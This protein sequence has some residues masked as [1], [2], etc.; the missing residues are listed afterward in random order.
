MKDITVRYYPQFPDNP[1]NPARCNRATATIDINK[2]VWENLSE[3]QRQWWMEHERGHIILNTGDEIAADAYAFQQVAG[4]TSYSLIQIINAMKAVV[5]GWQNDRHRAIQIQALQFAARKGSTYAQ[6]LLNKHTTMKQTSTPE[7]IAFNSGNVIV[8][9]RTTDTIPPF[10]F[11]RKAPNIQGQE[12]PVPQEPKP[13]APIASEPPVPTVPTSNPEPDININDEI[14]PSGAF[15]M[16]IKGSTTEADVARAEADAAIASAGAEAAP[17]LYGVAQTE[18]QNLTKIIA[19][20]VIVIT[21]I[22]I[23][24]LFLRQ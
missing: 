12:V 14:G 20:A 10:E 2:K 1:K 13:I 3:L 24:V 5:P 8:P 15:E 9:V 21:L 7:S 17:D 16:T 23:L 22:V 19:S 11:M 6:D 4:S 18:S